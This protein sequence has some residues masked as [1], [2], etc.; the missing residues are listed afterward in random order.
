VLRAADH[1]RIEGA[2]RRRERAEADLYAAARDAHEHGASLR[3]IARAAGVSHHGDEGDM[4]EA[5]G[6][7]TVVLELAILRA[8]A[9]D[10]LEV[11]VAECR[12]AG[13]DEFQLRDATVKALDNVP[14][15]LILDPLLERRIIDGVGE[16]HVR[17]SR[18]ISRQPRLSD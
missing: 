16:W 2:L 5:P 17:R 10:S 8:A 6:I 11:A 1:R 9:L 15:P 3:E 4:A 13:V 14:G 12:D 7:G 18:A